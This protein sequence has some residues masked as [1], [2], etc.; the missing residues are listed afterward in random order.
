MVLFHIPSISWGLSEDQQLS[1]TSKAAYCCPCPPVQPT[2][3]QRY[4]KLKV[5]R[6]PGGSARYARSKGRMDWDDRYVVSTGPNIVVAKRR[7]AIAKSSMCHENKRDAGCMY[8]HISFDAYSD[9]HVL[10]L[11]LSAGVIALCRAV[12]CCARGST[13]TYILVHTSSQYNI[14]RK[15]TGF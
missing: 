6:A 7:L 9:R 3:C 10:G 11:L 15:S 4:N 12:I 2:T 13:T 5:L 1:N 14:A 8:V